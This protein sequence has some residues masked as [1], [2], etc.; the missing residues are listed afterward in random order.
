MNENNVYLHWPDWP[1]VLLLP[2]F[3]QQTIGAI[4]MLGKS[5]CHPRVTFGFRVNLKLTEWS[6]FSAGLK[7][8]NCTV[9][10]CHFAHVLHCHRALRILPEARQKPVDTVFVDQAGLR[11]EESEKRCRMGDAEHNSGNEHFEGAQTAS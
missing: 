10:E 11:F 8:Y 6:V 7:L 5:G 9:F 4:L 3:A 1:S 2:T